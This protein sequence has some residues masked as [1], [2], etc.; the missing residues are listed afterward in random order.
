MEFPSRE[1]GGEF[2][3]KE[4]NMK[5]KFDKGRLLSLENRELREQ[6]AGLVDLVY[7]LCEELEVILNGGDTDV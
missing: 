3:S 6:V 5:L 2:L 7:Q 1:R 4:G